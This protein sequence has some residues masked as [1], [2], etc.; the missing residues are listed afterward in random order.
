MIELIYIP[1]L[2]LLMICIITD[3]QKRTIPD[4]ITL[5]GT[6]YFL[7]IHLVVK[8]ITIWQSLIGAI[9][10][11]SIALLLA[12]MSKG[13]LGGG[14]IKLFAMVGACLGWS[15]GIWAF[16]FTFPLAAFVA[17][18]LLLLRKV[19][20]KTFHVPNELPL[21]PFIGISCFLLMVLLQK[22]AETYV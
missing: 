20:P 8:D 10:L 9:G 3:C 19:A 7:L 16:L 6:V 1:F 4:V 21:A 22:V 13:K 18:P 11:G 14:D 15:A 5:P 2:V 17:L 12:I